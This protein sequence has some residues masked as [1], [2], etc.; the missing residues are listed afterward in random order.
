M[1]SNRAPY[2]ERGSGGGI[3]PII[4]M[5][6]EREQ[7]EVRYSFGCVFT[8]SVWV[9]GMIANSARKAFAAATDEW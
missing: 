4:G 9:K 1:N 6:T 3:A 5:S 8:A 7:C 2:G